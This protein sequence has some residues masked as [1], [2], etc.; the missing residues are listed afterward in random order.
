M[1]PTAR[2]VAWFF[3]CSGSAGNV[4]V[5]PIGAPAVGDERVVGLD[6]HRPVDVVLEVPV[7]R[8][9]L[10]EE[11]VDAGVAGVAQVQQLAGAHRLGD[12]SADE[13][14]AEALNFLD[15]TF[16]AGLRLS[17]APF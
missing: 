17:H 1:R 13:R 9:G 14:L 8:V 6:R 10:R 16:G 4:G 15:P 5:L 11:R 7:G 3:T 2:R 12:R